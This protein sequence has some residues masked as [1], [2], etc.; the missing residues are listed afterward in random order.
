[1]SASP[2]DSGDRAR[3]N[4]SVLGKRW[5]PQW[6]NLESEQPFPGVCGLSNYCAC[7]KLQEQPVV[8]LLVQQP[9]P[10]CRAARQA[11][12]QA[13]GLTRLILHDLEKTLEA[14]LQLRS[15]ESP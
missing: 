12:S 13:I 8:T 1:M 2:A 3:T 6:T 11:F 5:L 14:T 9:T 4:L 10:T 7:L 15:V